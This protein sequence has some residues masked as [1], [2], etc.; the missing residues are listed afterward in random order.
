MTNEKSLDHE[1]WHYFQWVYSKSNSIKMAISMDHDIHLHT[2]NLLIL[3]SNNSIQQISLFSF[4]FFSFLVLVVLFYIYSNKE[5][6]KYDAVRY[7][8]IIYYVINVYQQSICEYYQEFVVLQDKIN[9][10]RDNNDINEH[11][12]QM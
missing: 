9:R 1:K 5:R 7:C 10:K 8:V 12:L 2:S 4:L 3:K 6:K 11:L